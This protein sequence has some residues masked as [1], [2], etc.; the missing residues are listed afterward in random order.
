VPDGVSRVSTDVKDASVSSLSDAI[1]SCN[2]L[3][4]DEQI[5]DR[6]SVIGSDGTGMIDVL[7]R[8]DQHVGWSRWAD[9]SKCKRGVRLGDDGGRDDPGNDL[10]K[11]TIHDASH[12]T[13]SSATLLTAI[14]PPSVLS[15]THDS[16][17]GA[18]PHR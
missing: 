12:T 8:N 18:A 13:E 16:M 9:V 2:F 15:N 14:S 11:Q 17:L 6:R 1:D 4:G 10:A 5:C 7:F 3:C